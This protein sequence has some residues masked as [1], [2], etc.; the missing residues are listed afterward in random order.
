MD[1]QGDSYNAGCD[2]PSSG[3]KEHND[4]RTD[5]FQ[6]DIGDAD[7]SNDKDDNLMQPQTGKNLDG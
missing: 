4:M 7:L 1:G 2:C 3:Q 6:K 5:K